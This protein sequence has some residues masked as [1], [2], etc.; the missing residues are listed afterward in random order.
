[1]SAFLGPIHHWLYNKIQFQEALIQSLLETAARE[2]WGA[3]SAEKLDAACG[4]ADLR[5]LEESIDT[6]NIHGWLQQKIGVI[7][8]RLAFLVTHL[9]KEEPSRIEGLKQ[10]AY[11]FGENYPLEAGL[12]ADAAFKALGDILLD[13]MPCDHVNRVVEQGEE[14]TV[15]QQTQC[16]HQMHWEQAGGEVSVYYALRAQII[17]GM[18]AQSG[19]RFYAAG[20][21]EFEIGKD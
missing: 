11:R 16:V 8:S 5:P 15:W 4:K 6:G 19:L 7:E 2:G 20:N 21:G 17:K 9:L 14:K 3:V 12:G 18:L 1:M 10:A 13:G